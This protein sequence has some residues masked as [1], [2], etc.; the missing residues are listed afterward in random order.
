MFQQEA[1]VIRHFQLNKASIVFE[2][3]A[4]ST[5]NRI[6][7]NM[8]V[9]ILFPDCDRITCV[10]IEPSKVFSF[11][12]V[13]QQA[14]LEYH[15][16]YERV[17][18]KPIIFST[19]SISCIVISRIIQTSNLIGI[20]SSMYDYATC[21]TKSCPIKRRISFFSLEFCSTAKIG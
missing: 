14:F 17:H 16:S 10:P 20:I 18:H 12:S 8:F 11:V 9:N 4:H 2:S 5:R 19:G 13:H 1:T 21:A 6:V 15:P 7:I 3:G